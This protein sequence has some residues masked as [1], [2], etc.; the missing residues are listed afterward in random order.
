[1]TLD[2]TPDAAREQLAALRRL[3]GNDRLAQAL[4]LSEVVR[5]LAVTGREDRAK[6]QSEAA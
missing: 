6:N 2:T 5:E 4:E 3:S 1:M